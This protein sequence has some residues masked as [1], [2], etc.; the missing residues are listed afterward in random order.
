MTKI[1][2]QIGHY[3]VEGGAAYEVETLKK[4]YPHVVERLR[5]SG[6]EVGEFDGSLR[7]EPGSYQYKYDGAVFL[8]C[9]S[10]GTTST[11][12]SIGYWAEKHPG[13]RSLAATLKKVYGKVTGLRFIGYNITNG[14]HHYYGNRRFAHS[15]KCTLLEC[16]FV[17]NPNER[18]YLQANGKKFGYAIADAYIQH[19]GGT[20]PEEDEM[21]LATRAEIITRGGT[22]RCRTWIDKGANKTLWVNVSNLGSKDTTVRYFGWRYNGDMM[23]QAIDAN[24]TPS[25]TAGDGDDKDA[26][27]F[28]GNT[29]SGITLTVECIKGGPVL[30]EWTKTI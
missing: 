27:A 17:S 12:F 29:S 2:V 3:P 10:G 18:A 28:F 5:T 30:C 11:G 8:H 6:F 13:S 21:G 20:Q 23:P 15:C 22:A 24:L 9:D 4:I 7:N 16:G 19:F 14:E 25:Q 26:A 1:A